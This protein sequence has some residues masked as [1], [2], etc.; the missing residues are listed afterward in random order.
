MQNFIETDGAGT[1]TLR[2]LDVRNALY[3][4]DIPLTPREFEKLWMR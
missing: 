1:G 3:G 2:R 4:F